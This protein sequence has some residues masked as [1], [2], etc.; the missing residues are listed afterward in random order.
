[1]K[2]IE[3]QPAK[4]ITSKYTT[5]KYTNKNACV[6]EN[7]VKNN[8]LQYNSAYCTNI[9]FKAGSTAPKVKIESI[10]LTNYEEYL[11]MTEDK[12][13]RFRRLYREFP[14]VLSSSQKQRLLEIDSRPEFMQLPLQEEKTMD[15]FIKVAKKYSK[16]KDNPILCLGRD[17]KWFLEASLCMKNGINDYNYVAFS[18]SWFGSGDDTLSEEGLT[19]LKDKMPTKAEE[20]AYKKYLKSIQADPVS[21]VSKTQ[22]TGKKTIITAFVDSGKSITS[23]LDLMSRYAEEQGVLEEFAH[24]FDIVTLNCNKN[25]QERLKQHV[26]DPEVLMPEKLQAYSRPTAQLGQ[27]SVIEQYHFNMDHDV[28]KQLI[29]NRNAHECRSTYYPHSA[30]TV[31]HP[32]KFRTG[33]V[34]D[35]DKIKMLTS[36]IRSEGTIFN[37]EPVMSA[38]RNLLNFRILDGLSQRGLCKVMHRVKL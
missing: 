9:T 2:V 36:H 10:P 34:E 37:F 7:S 12:K 38:Y 35:L 1:M 11:S 15:N 17:P 16:F 32:E 8:I 22:A 20:K 27:G 6:S 26:S 13:E 31:Y 25:R 29:D 19:L 30:W 3:I 23:F 33:K 4:F 28:Y 21:I 18:G 24:S 5:K 14:D